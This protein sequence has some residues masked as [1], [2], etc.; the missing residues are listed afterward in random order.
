MT[1]DAGTKALAAC[2]LKKNVAKMNAQLCLKGNPVFQYFCRFVA[3]VLVLLCAN[4]LGHA[5]PNKKVRD[6]NIW[7]SDVLECS[8]EVFRQEPV[9]LSFGFVRE[10]EP[11]AVVSPFFSSGYKLLPE[12]LLK[13]VVDGE[14]SFT[15]NFESA[16]N[17]EGRWYF[18]NQDNKHALLQAM[19]NGKSAK[20]MVDAQNGKQEIDLSLSGLTA[21]LLFMDEAQGRVGKTDA[22]KAKGEGE[23]VN[24]AAGLTQLK[25]SAQL[26]SRLAA[27]WREQTS[28]CAIGWN[29]DSDLIAD[30]GGLSIEQKY[31]SQLFILP[32]GTPGAYN[33]PQVV[34]A[35]DRESKKSRIVSLPIMGQRGPTTLDYPYNTSWDHHKSELSSFFKGRGLG[36]CGM[37]ARWVWNEGGFEGGFE[38]VEE[39]VKD[40]CDG[41]YDEW[42][43][44]WPPE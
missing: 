36:D 3:A 25:S 19:M 26:P 39:R 27:F 42:P 11:N 32:C 37:Q 38:L 31:G 14:K 21:V 1:K 13:I 12:S 10:S 6:W 20:L 29:D 40:D 22:I 34:I 7:C 44:I 2:Q 41:K 9:Y 16:D 15:L 17:D 23:P 8:A 28:G 35:Y 30:F 43:V 5:G 33:L 4:S 18:H 24:A